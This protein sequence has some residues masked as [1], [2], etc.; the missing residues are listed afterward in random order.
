M[1]AEYAQTGRHA[2]PL[3]LQPDQP[4]VGVVGTYGWRWKAG[5]RFA[6]L[7]RRPQDDEQGAVVQ[8]MVLRYYRDGVL[9]K[10]LAAEYGYS[11]RRVQEYLSGKGTSA[12][13]LWWMAY[14]APVL[15]ALARL[16]YPVTEYCN[17]RKRL[18]VQ[19]EAC[20]RALS[21]LA[22][23]VADDPRPLARRL[24][25]DMRLLTETVP[26]GR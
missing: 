22:D 9:R 5:T 19:A 10:T 15:R 20:R 26:E 17:R 2:L 13:C 21:T 25:Q 6:V 1:A 23:L 14:S 18:G 24:T 4:P 16:G 3:L 11:E 8:W 7:E 12:R